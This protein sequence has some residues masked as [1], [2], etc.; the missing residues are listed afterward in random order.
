MD[1]EILIEV[2]KIYN[3]I[4]ELVKN[5]TIKNL[6]MEALE[7][8]KTPYN[9][10]FFLD[11]LRFM[12]AIANTDGVLTRKEANVMNYITEHPFTLEEYSELID[13]CGIDSDFLSKAPLTFILLCN[14]ENY[15]YKS[16]SSLEFSVLNI[17]ISFFEALGKVIALSDNESTTEEV[18]NIKV[19]IKTLKEY[20]EE[21]TLSPFYNY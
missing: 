8:T 18:Q 14:I 19:F 21:N 3:Q 15:L 13:K 1:H 16:G 2:K 20:A 10:M 6:I 5:P 7:D 4:D 11:T 12:I 9:E 17:L